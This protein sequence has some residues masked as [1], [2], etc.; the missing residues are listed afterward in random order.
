M[1]CMEQAYWTGPIAA[2]GTGD[3]GMLVGFGVCVP[4]YAG[5]RALERRWRKGRGVDEMMDVE[6]EVGEVD[7]EKGGRGL[8]LGERVRA[9]AAGTGRKRQ[10]GPEMSQR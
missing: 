2:R 1:L 8:G 6:V 3:I 9:L 7:A 4:V 5:V 10:D